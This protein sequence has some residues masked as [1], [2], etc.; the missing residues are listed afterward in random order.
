M[1]GEEGRPTR[2]GVGVGRGR[3]RGLKA[4][5]KKLGQTPPSNNNNKT[6]FEKENEK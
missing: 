1:G 4:D 2:E 5:P 6:I 3:G